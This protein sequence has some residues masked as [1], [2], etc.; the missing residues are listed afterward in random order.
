MADRHAQQSGGSGAHQQIPEPFVTFYGE[1]C[2]HAGA[3]ARASFACARVSCGVLPNKTT[4]CIIYHPHARAHIELTPTTWM[5]NVIL[6]DTVT[7][8]PPNDNPKAGTLLVTTFRLLF[9]VR[10]D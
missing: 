6:D 9:K 8:L 3:F 10:R 5:R 7:Y 1:E 2:L 4:V